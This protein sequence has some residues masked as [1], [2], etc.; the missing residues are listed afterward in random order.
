MDIRLLSQ[1]FTVRRLDARDVDLIYELSRKN[2]LFYKY[3]S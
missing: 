3:L 2:E 1:R